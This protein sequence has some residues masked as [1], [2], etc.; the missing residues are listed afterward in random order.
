MM[1]RGGV[2]QTGR[3]GFVCPCVCACM[4]KCACVCLGRLGG[5]L[6]VWRVFG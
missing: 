2:T 5:G 6:G 3:V 1:E 4:F